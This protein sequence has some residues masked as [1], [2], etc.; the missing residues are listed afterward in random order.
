MSLVEATIILL[1]LMLLT[2]VMAPSILD[3]VNDAK[4]VKVKEDCEALGLLTAYWHSTL[5]CL[6]FSASTACTLA[7]RVDILFSDG[8]TITSAIL[9]DDAATDYTAPASTLNTSPINWDDFTTRGDA[10]QD[11]WVTNQ[12]GYQF[13]VPKNVKP[14]PP[15][16]P[17]ELQSPVMADPWGNKY[18]INS[19]FLAIATDAA[20]GSGEG[21]RSGSWL[22]KAFCLSP[23]ANGLYQTNFAGT[24]ATSAQRPCAVDRGG[25]DYFYPIGCV[26]P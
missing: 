5:G 11:Q 1:V 8:N 12:P 25:D 24:L 23:G 20:A 14:W 17:P 4:R 6:R 13:T 16:H 21:Q 7:N 22:R 9:Q 3:F 26:N 18:V 2:G 10:F 15:A 19:V